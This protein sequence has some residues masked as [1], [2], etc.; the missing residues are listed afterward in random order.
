MTIFPRL[1]RLCRRR[2]PRV[3]LASVGGL[4]LLLAPLLIPAPA[5]AHTY[6]LPQLIE[7]ATKNNAGLAASAQATLG[8]EAQLLE[9][10]RSWMPTGELLQLITA[11]PAIHCQTDLPLPAGKDPK[12]W[13]QEHCDNTNVSEATLKFNGVF[14]RTEVRLTQ[15]L[16]TFGKIAAGV[17]AAEAGVTASKSRED[18]QRAELELNVRRAYW[19]AKLAREVL[20]TLKEGLG[21]LAEAEARINQDLSAGT[22]SASPTDRFRLAT[23]RAQVETQILEAT[24]LGKVARNG[25]RALIGDAAPADFD[26]DAD[27]LGAVTVPVRPLVHYEEQARLTR[28]EVKA[29]DF[30]LKSKRSLADL[31]RRKQ[32]P[33]LVLVGTATFA[34]ASSV[35]NPKNA[36][37]NDPFNTLAGGLGAALRIPLDL[38]VKNARADRASADAEEAAY[39]RREALGGIRFEVDRSYDELTEA[40]DRSQVVAKGEKNGR[41]WIMSV[42]ANFD[43]GLAETRDFSDALVAFFQNRIKY[44]QSLM[45]VNLAAAALSRAT[46]AD[47]TRAN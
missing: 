11:S 26:I 44:L 47:V 22:G 14:T 30:L 32:Y 33:D 3:A 34:Y 20:D 35:D 19:G 45:D 31:E 40:M 16:Y 10:R 37:A 13:R 28:P 18:A 36:F 21:Y 8:I 2:F 7:L 46:G 29:L 38:G 4:A 5:Q 27:P 39:R 25:L 41:R 15:P 24:R 12:D 9:A 17:Q 1:C 23:V 6:T 43:L 42:K